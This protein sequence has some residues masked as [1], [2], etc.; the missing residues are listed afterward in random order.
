MSIPVKWLTT[1]EAAAYIRRS[2]SFLE[3]LRAAGKGPKYYTPEGS[4]KG[5]IYKIS[6]LDLYMEEFDNE[7]TDSIHF[8]VKQNER[9]ASSS[10]Q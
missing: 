1:E 8:A 2:I 4:R 10:V 7:T 3:K 5:I 9:Q 6:D